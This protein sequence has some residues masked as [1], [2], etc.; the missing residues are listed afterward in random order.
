MRH[1]FQVAEHDRRSERARQSS[2]LLV[3]HVPKLVLIV[4]LACSLRDDLVLIQAGRLVEISPGRAGF[5]SYRDSMGDPVE[6]VAY[7]IAIADCTGAPNQDQKSGLEGILNVLIVVE[8]SPANAQDHRPVSCHQSG[9]RHLV[10]IGDKPIEQLAFTQAGNGPS[11]E[12]TVQL[13]QDGT[14]VTAH[15]DSVLTSF[16][17]VSTLYLRRRGDSNLSFFNIWRERKN[18]V[19]SNGCAVVGLLLS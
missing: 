12:D 3:E 19:K 18:L 14:R 2:Q 5:R 8:N 7:E 16:T 15:G 1:S 10:S 11:I 17:V 9:E 4:V 13:F 6:P